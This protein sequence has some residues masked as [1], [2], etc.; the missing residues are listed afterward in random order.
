MAK[1]NAEEYKT[2][3]II[4]KFCNN[5]AEFWYASEL[6]P[7]LEYTKWENFSKVINRAMLACKNSGV[8]GIYHFPEVRK[9]VEIGSGAKRW[10]TDYE[11]SRYACYLI[12]QNGGARGAS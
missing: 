2:F 5:S 9:M 11:L 10:K 7:A 4:K 3:E 8:E 6:A 12:V 1:L